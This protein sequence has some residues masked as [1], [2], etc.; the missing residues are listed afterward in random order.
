MTFTRS[1]NKTVGLTNTVRMWSVQPAPYKK[2]LPF[3]SRTARQTPYPGI[4]G[5]VGDHMYSVTTSNDSDDN[6]SLVIATNAAR[7]KLV[8]KVNEGQ[9]AALGLTVASWRSSLDMIAGALTSLASKRVRAKRYYS[10]KTSELY[11]EGVFGWLPLIDDIWKAYNVL[12]TTYPTSRVHSS[13]RASNFSMKSSSTYRFSV[14]HKVSVRAAA[15]VR[16]NNL[17]LALLNQLGLL[18]P[19]AI[20]WDAVP[21]SFVLNWFIPVGT[22]LN[23]LTDFVGLDVF[24]EYY[25]AFRVKETGGSILDTRKRPYVWVPRACSQ[26]STERKLGIPPYQLPRVQLPTVNLTKALIAFS[27]FDSARESTPPRRKFR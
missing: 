2:P 17:N 23:S 4:P 24:D 18:N 3:Y 7:T 15:T 25:T 12:Q 6:N 9:I 14:H 1:I 16:V 20:A 5:L 13:G 21:Y 27:L 22:M 19:A 11:L 8:D 10:K 26:V